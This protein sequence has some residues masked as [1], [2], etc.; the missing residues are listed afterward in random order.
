MVQQCECVD[1]G[2]VGVEWYGRVR[3]VVGGDGQCGELLLVAQ[4]DVAG[5]NI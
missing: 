2:V 4:Y 5:L 1:D 3:G